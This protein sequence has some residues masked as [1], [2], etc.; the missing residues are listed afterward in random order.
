[1]SASQRTGTLASGDVTLFYRHFGSPGRMPVLIFH[2]ANYYDSGDWID[3]AAALSR[4]RE[5]V[6]FDT[7]GFGESSWSPGKDYSYDAIMADANALLRHFGWRRAVLMGHSLGGSYA[8]I[9]AARFPQ[10]AAGLVLVDHCPGRVS[11]STVSVNNKP[12]VF[13]TIEAALAETSREK[14]IARGSPAWTRVAAIFRPVE[15]GFVFRR[16]PDFGNRVP[17]ASG[18]AATLTPTDTWG[19][20]AEVRVPTLI[21][22]G[23]RSDRYTPEALARVDKD[24]PRVR[25]VHVEAGHDIPGAAPEALIRSVSE[26]LAANVDAEKAA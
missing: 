15:G 14:S 25:L 16:D 26:F 4:E 21:L 7:R 1:M 9:F 22:R 18:W 12:K 13:P 2:G 24:F 3:V 11:P 23:T 19:E 17:I 6:A 8:L 5:V 20:L 10:A